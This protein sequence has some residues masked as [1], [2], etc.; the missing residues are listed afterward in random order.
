[1]RNFLLLIS[2]WYFHYEYVYLMVSYSFLRLSL[3]FFLSLFFGL[4]SIYLIVCLFFLCQFMST[5]EPFQ[6]VPHMPHYYTFQP[7][8]FPFVSLLQFVC[9]YNIVIIPFFT[10]LI[11]VFF[12]SQYM[13]I[14]VTLKSFNEKSSIWSLSWGVSVACFFSGV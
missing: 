12:S 7:P 11:M 9:W 14:M 10:S 1:M 2:F 5:I 6:W 13:F 8:K 4:F 3:L